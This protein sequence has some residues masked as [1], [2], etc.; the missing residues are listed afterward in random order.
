M[1]SDNNDFIKKLM[2]ASVHMSLTSALEDLRN[3][4]KIRGNVKGAFRISDKQ[5]RHL[6]YDDSIQ[7]DVTDEDML[8]L[9]IDYAL[10]S[11]DEERFMLLT[12]ELKG[13]GVL[14]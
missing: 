9:Q 7:T 3:D 8:L 2:M 1:N 11:G 6:E 12:G 14:V 5:Y 10:D 13:M 4:S